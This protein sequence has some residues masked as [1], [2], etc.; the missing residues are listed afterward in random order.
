MESFYGRLC[1]EF[2]NVNEFITMY[3]VREKLQC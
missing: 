3:D 2:L 1:I